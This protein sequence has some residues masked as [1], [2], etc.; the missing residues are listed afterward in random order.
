MAFGVRL[1][2]VDF[3][4]IGHV[5]HL[6]TD[7]GAS[8]RLRL[9][10]RTVADFHTRYMTALRELGLKKQVWALECCNADGAR[11]RRAG[12]VLSR[13]CGIP[14]QPCSVTIGQCEADHPASHSAVVDPTQPVAS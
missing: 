3:D 7:D 6:R 11:P 14:L 12:H 10:P 5:L 1:L 13:R 2:T 4:F 9:E 8:R